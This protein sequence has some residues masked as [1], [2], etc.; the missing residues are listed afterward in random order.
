MNSCAL[1]IPTCRHTL[2]N[3]RHCLQPAVRRRACCRHHLDAQAR[4]HNMARA[5][6]RTFILRLRVPETAR[7]LAWNKT[8][9]NRILAT[10][11]LDPDAALMMLWAMDLTAET[12]RSE[13][14]S[15]PRRAQNRACNPNE[16]YD[17]SLNPL[18]P[19]SLSVTLSQMIENTNS[20]REGVHLGA[21]CQNWDSPVGKETL[22]SNH[23]GVWV[24][25][26]ASRC[27]EPALSM[28]GPAAHPRRRQLQLKRRDH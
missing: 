16:I 22:P 25:P 2:P 28:H 27:P 23:A 17:V 10:E 4:L 19:R 3:G 21:S 7:D 1:I 24:S 6:R 26:R 11:R 14:T 20:Q 12:L 5:R 9:L 13:S 15:R 18:L 8:E